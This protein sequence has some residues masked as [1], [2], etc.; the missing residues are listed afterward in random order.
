MLLQE[1]DNKYIHIKGKDN[2]LADKI[3]RLFSVN[4]YK[5]PTEDKLQHPHIA[6]N[7]G[8]SSNVTD[9][10]QLLDTGTTQQQLNVITKLSEVYK[11]K[12]DSAE[13]KS[14]SYKQVHKINFTLIRKIF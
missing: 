7:K 6:Q 2:I 4:I 11:H 12:T 9:S 8:K 3:S 1:Y 14:A 10:V 13:G 5:D